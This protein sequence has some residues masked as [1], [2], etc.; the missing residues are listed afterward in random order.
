MINK[1]Y[2]PISTTVLMFILLLC[3][4]GKLSGQQYATSQT[5]GVTGICLFCG[6]SDPNNAVNNTNLSDYS[7]FNITAGLLGVSVQQTLI[8]PATSITGCDSLIIGIGSGNALLSVNLLGGITVQT[9]NGSAANNDVQSITGNILR[10]LQVSNRGEI[11]LKPQQQFDRVKVTL[12]SSL[13]GLLN[14]F[15]LYY[16]YRKSAIS[17]PVAPNSVALCQGDTTILQAT[18]PPGATI[19]WYN[20]SSGGTLLATGSSYQVSPA[21]TTTYYAEAASGGC[22]SS[23]KPI[24]VQVN[25]RP[26][27][28]VYSVPQGYV[29]GS[30]LLSVSNHSNGI[31]Y[32]VNIH[33]VPFETP[34]YDTS[35][36]VVNNN[37]ITTPPVIFGGGGTAT[38]GVQAVNPITGCKSDV[39]NSNIVYG[40]SARLPDVNAD[41]ITICKGD[42]ASFTASNPIVN[43]VI[44]RWY[45]APTGGNLLFT[46][47][48]FKTS[49]AVTTSYYV[50][51][52]FDCEFPIRKA[53]TV[54]VKKL[55]NPQYNIPQGVVCGSPVIKIT[56]HQNGFNYR[57]RKTDRFFGTIVA[58][59]SFLIINRDSINVPG[60]TTFFS[61]TVTLA[62][63]AVDPVSGCRSD[64]VSGIYIQG[65]VAA[66]PTTNFDS[67]TICNGTD[68]TLSA[69]VPGFT[70]AIIY[71]YDAPSGGNLLYTGKNYKVSPGVNT[72]YYVTAG[73]YCIFPQ[74]KPVKVN[75]VNCPAAQQTWLPQP[76]AHGATEKLIIYPNPATHRVS[77]GNSTDFSGSLLIICD[78]NGRE[79]QRTMIDRNT[80]EIR[81]QLPGGYYQIQ[82]ITKGKKVFNGNIIL[83]R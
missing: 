4:P 64:T 1:P 82:V 34:A 45:D 78:L 40:A 7:T 73:G 66:L 71:W 28:P 22:V 35:Y 29:C 50:S 6:V 61:T 33:F 69:Y 49:P 41:T 55:P 67:V 58:D 9:Y 46:G 80:L 53:V 62:V 56:N 74:R 31:N 19:K 72:T 52:G 54:I 60:L 76:T 10:L 39:I 68:T 36:T 21:T 38:I 27:N 32:K 20:A 51:A 63:Q 83:Y 18:P 75:V 3:L 15:Q 37:V 44:F 30:A 24:T 59:T 81:P 79:M 16:A 5:N 47:K 14:S 70:S 57:V 25:P 48:T 65:S 17:A 43:I 77:F 8:F 2:N 13:L 26:A 23:R 42:T 11:T 12:S